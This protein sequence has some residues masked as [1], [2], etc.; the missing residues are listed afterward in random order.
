V[1]QAPILRRSIRRLVMT[2]DR[3]DRWTRR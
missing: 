1:Q 2:R 3:F